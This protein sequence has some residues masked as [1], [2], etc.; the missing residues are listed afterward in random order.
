[1]LKTIIFITFFIETA[2]QT[3]IFNSVKAFTA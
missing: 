1:M 3:T 2:I